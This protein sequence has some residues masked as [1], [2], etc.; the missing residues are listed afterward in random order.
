MKSLALA[1][2]FN[3]ALGMPNH[4]GPKALHR[5]TELNRM[6]LVEFEEVEEN[7]DGDDGPCSPI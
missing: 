7:D 5:L 3:L 1:L 2:L 6:S 4:I